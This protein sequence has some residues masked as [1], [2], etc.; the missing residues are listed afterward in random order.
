MTP[1]QHFGSTIDGR[2]V[3]LVVQAVAPDGAPYA[4]QTQEIAL[5]RQ[6]RNFVA[7]VERGAHVTVRGWITSHTEGAKLEVDQKGFPEA[8][9]FNP[10]TFFV[11]FNVHLGIADGGNGHF[12]H[13]TIRASHA[14]DRPAFS[15]RSVFRLPDERYTII[16]RPF[17]GQ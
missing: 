3:S 1:L 4:G 7:Y 12:G 13:V 14:Q 2:V 5:F 8:F 17:V 9:R 15:W 16:F 6:G 10:A 11:S